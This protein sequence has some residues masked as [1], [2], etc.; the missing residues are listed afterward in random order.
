M[1]RGSGSSWA[2]WLTFV[3]M[4]LVQLAW[5]LGLPAFQG[6]DEFDHVFKAEAVAH[7][8]LFPSGEVAQHGR[9]GIVA[10]PADVADAAGPVCRSY[11]YTGHDNCDAIT[12]RSDGLVTIASAAATYNPVWYA[13][14]GLAARPFSG[15][16]ADYAMRIAVSI[17][18]ALL[19][20]WG[21][22]VTRRWAHDGWPMLGYCL[23]LTPVLVYSSSIAS[24]NGIEYSGALLTWA[25]AI[26]L[27]RSERPTAALLPFAVGSFALC[28]AHS[29]GVV[30]LAVIALAMLLLAPRQ[31]WVG[32]A[33]EHRRLVLGSLAAVGAT[34]LACGS[35]VVLA[36]TNAPDSNG[37]ESFAF[38]AAR[39]AVQDFLWPFQAVAAFP[40]REQPAPPAV[41][42]MWLLPLVTVLLM[43]T[44][45]ADRRLRRAALLVLGVSIVL[46]TAL[47]A[48][49]YSMMGTA[50]QGRYS[51][52]LYVGLPLLAG[53]A[54]TGKR[55]LRRVH[56]HVVMGLLAGATAIGLAHVAGTL[57][58]SRPGPL[59]AA[60]LVSHGWL[61]VSV[62]AAV[63]TL[64]LAWLFGPVA[65]PVTTPATAPAT[66]APAE[67]VRHPVASGASTS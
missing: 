29:T 32:L 13:V 62:L 16:A 21:A 53:A 19:C 4:S 66:P 52:P 42:A 39:I 12:T 41:Y 6:I 22:A 36:R 5:I 35:Y 61:L 44:R 14:M 7:G 30:W 33:R 47:T 15:A 17:V 3:G 56:A 28:T 2:F 51:L 59:S 25:A 38:D 48:A 20:A 55:L 58:V 43:A 10:V 11:K 57:V 9:G 23:A 49:T 37:G 46:P 24:P 26:A 27:A 8:Q 64:T 18:C 1:T 45:V 40:M 31:H 50:W 65:S 63:G 34:V 54:L 60:E 67:P